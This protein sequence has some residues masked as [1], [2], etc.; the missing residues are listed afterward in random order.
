MKQDKLKLKGKMSTDDDVDAGVFEQKDNCLLNDDY[1]LPFDSAHCG[2]F[3]IIISLLESI[4][5]IIW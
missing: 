1:S 4:I 2:N 5:Y 3:S